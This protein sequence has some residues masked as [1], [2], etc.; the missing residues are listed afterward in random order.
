[1]PK[2][3]VIG[4]ERIRVTANRFQ[5]GQPNPSGSR[6]LTASEALTIS[7]GDRWKALFLMARMFAVATIDA[8]GNPFLQ[9]LVPGDW[10]IRLDNGTAHVVTD[11]QFRAQFRLIEPPEGKR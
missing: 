6:S 4:A 9:L 11:E 5:I 10:M 1:M 7:N 8:S 2:Y 3:E